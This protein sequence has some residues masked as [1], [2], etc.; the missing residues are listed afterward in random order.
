MRSSRRGLCGGNQQGW[1]AISRVKP[2]GE[3]TFH[4]WWERCLDAAGV[5]YRNPHVTRHTFATRWLR[6]GGRLE[7]LSMVMG[8]AS[9]RTTFDLY[10]HLDT[11][12]VLADMEKFDAA[13]TFRSDTADLQE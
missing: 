3:G 1:H 7:T 6:R 9:I 4:R 12:D 11:R 5:R 13:E 8:H 10:G 2:I